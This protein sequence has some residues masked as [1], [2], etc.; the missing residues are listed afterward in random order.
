MVTM[1]TIDELFLLVVHNLPQ[2]L[3]VVLSAI[4]GILVILD[5]INGFRRPFLKPD[6]WQ[7]LPLVD[8]KILTHNTRRFRFALPHEEQLLG[9]PVG[10]HITLKVTLP[11]GEE[12][13][14]PYTPTTE[15]SQ[16]G[17][18][19]FV[20]KVYPEGRMS[21]ALDALSIGNRVLFKGPKGRFNYEQGK[22]SA[23]GMLAGGTGI[24]PM[25]QV[26]QHI[27]R[28][29]NDTT[30]IS[31]IFGNVTEDDILLKDELQQLAAR[32]PGCLR[33]Y[34]VLDKPPK[35]WREG[36]GFITEN[37]IKEVMPPPGEGVIVLRC[38]PGPMN[39]AME[40]CLDALGYTKDMQF[41]F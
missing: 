32:R 15:T 18:V 29:P 37:M 27:L 41:Q 2:I 13:L 17:F 14:R 9:L 8:K 28:D 30:K 12:V 35:N 38:G 19:D 4:I 21:Q 40:G 33:V 25:Y 20:I 39:K 3:L 5:A 31:L 6:T 10:Q 26:I 34:Q 7:P 36:A 22:Y 1:A 24:T 16:R 23:I 11:S